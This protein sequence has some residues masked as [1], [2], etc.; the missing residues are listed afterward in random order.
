MKRDENTGLVVLFSF[1]V[2]G[3]V[4]AGLALVLAPQSGRKTRKQIRE[5]A[6]DVKEQA[7][8]Y[9]ERLKEKVF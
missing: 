4:G 1:L 7:V 5:F 3:L 6:E 2:G 8:D 9:A